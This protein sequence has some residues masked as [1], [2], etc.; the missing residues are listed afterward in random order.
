MSRPVQSGD[1][2]EVVGGFNGTKSPNLGRI[3]YV[4]SFAGESEAFGRLWRCKAQ[5]LIYADGLPRDWA[6]FAQDWLRRIAP[7]EP[8]LETISTTKELVNDES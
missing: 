4:E 2:A 1:M 7:P 5:G 6:N 3:V 8:P